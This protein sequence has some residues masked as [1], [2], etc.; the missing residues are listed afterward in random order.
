MR[1]EVARRD[2]EGHYATVVPQEKV[3]LDHLFL[4]SGTLSSVEV[5]PP[6]DVCLDIEVTLT[7]GSMARWSGI[8]VVGEVALGWGFQ[9]GDRLKVSCRNVSLLDVFARVDLHIDLAQA[10]L[11]Y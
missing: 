3:V 6:E 10:I 5:R 4:S 7:G 2:D 11:M 8:Y 1:V 9:K